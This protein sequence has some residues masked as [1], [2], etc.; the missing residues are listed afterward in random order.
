MRRRAGRRHDVAWVARLRQRRRRAGTSS[1][2]AAAAGGHGARLCPRPAA[3]RRG[4][5]RSAAGSCSR[6]AVS[7]CRSLR[8]HAPRGARRRLAGPAAPRRTSPP[9][10]RR[11]CQSWAASRRRRRAAHSSGA[12]SRRATRRGDAE[13]R[14]RRHATCF[15]LGGARAACARCEA[16]SPSAQRLQLRGARPRAHRLT[17][18]RAH[19][20]CPREARRRRAR[21]RRAPTAVSGGAVGARTSSSAVARGAVAARQRARSSPRHPRRAASDHSASLNG[22]RAAAPPAHVEARRRQPPR[23]DVFSPGASIRVAARS[24][25][26]APGLPTRRR[27][28]DARSRSASTPGGDSA[29]ADRAVAQGA[30]ARHHVAPLLHLVRGARPRAARPPPPSSRD[31]K[32]ARCSGGER[33]AI[34]AVPPR[35]ATRS[36]AARAAGAPKPHVRLAFAAFC[37]RATQRRRDASR[38]LAPARPCRRGAASAAA[39]AAR[40]PRRRPAVGGASG[41]RHG[42]SSWPKRVKRGRRCGAHRARRPTVGRSGSAPVEQACRARPR[43]LAPRPRR[44]GTP[45]TRG[46]AAASAEVAARHL[47]RATR[48][49]SRDVNPRARST[50]SDL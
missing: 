36:P 34:A 25:G 32:R 3:H 45:S 19:T 4:D 43:L 9:S 37:A 48:R 40:A 22:G 39:A 7:L 41:T 11:V 31:W 2:R 5:P 23:S 1:R 38:R 47:A 27:S 35:G 20:R 15:D 10:S 30:R 50:G 6:R 8:P 18:A 42:G 17:R 13:S 28:A 29:E 14:V 21:T 46:P 33:V 44:A 24:I 16:A 12:R 49:A 26:G